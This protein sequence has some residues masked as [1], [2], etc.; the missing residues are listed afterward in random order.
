[1]VTRELEDYAHRCWRLQGG[2][3]ERLPV[4]FVTAVDLV[5]EVHLSMQAALQP[6]VDNAIAKTIHLK[7]DARLAELENL[8][9][10]ADRL[11]LK[12]LT[13]YR[14]GCSHDDV[15]RVAC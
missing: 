13:L 11:G 2:D 4:H 14:R 7:P 15:L 1:V 12:G 9:F 8:C 6:F 3:P 10:E 5:P